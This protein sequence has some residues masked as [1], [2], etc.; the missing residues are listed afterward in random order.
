[1]GLLMFILMRS[2]VMIQIV[3]EPMLGHIHARYLLLTPFG[4]FNSDWATITYRQL[5]GEDRCPRKWTPR[6]E[7]R[8]GE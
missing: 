5:V 4:D 1:M 7:K 2:E 8:D 6:E 3:E